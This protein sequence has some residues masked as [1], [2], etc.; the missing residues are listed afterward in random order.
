ML[1]RIVALVALIQV[2]AASALTFNLPA[3]EK[4]CF[5]IF[6]QKPRTQVSYYFAVQSGG[7]FDVDYEIKS[8][9]RRTI[10]GDTKSR[11]GSFVFE[12]DV[13]GEYE[14][15]FSN[16]MSTF[17][18]KV[19]DFEIKHEGDASSQFRASM[20]APSNQKPQQHVEGMKR[21][22]DEIDRQLDEL[23]YALSY[24]KTRNNR[25]Q[26]TVRSTESRIYYFSILEVLLMVGM[27]VLQIS[28]V[29]Y[30][31]R[32]SRKQLV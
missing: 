1:A 8:P 5:Y 13:V 11:Q 32:G 14:F 26:A 15:C 3:K 18:E 31:F 2:I 29:Q 4:A 9:S 21:T 27:A 19:V 24:Y 28:I 25:N 7:D 17:A 22:A 10:Y 23:K 16:E 30:F 6:T 12:A 20:P